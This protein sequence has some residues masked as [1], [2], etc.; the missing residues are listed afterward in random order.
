M[1]HLYSDKKNRLT[2]KNVTNLMTINLIGL[3]FETWNTT[4]FVKTW[5]R[6]NQSAN[7]PRSKH[8]VVEEFELSCG[9]LKLS[10]IRDLE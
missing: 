1:N 3:L 5:L 9:H 2:I 8:K 6:K 10:K 4:P 7:D